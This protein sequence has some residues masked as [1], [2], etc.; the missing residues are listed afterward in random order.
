MINENG[1]SAVRDAVILVLELH[2]G[3]DKVETGQR[4]SEDLEVDSF[5]LMNIVVIL[6]QDFD[7]RISETAAASVRTVG[8][9]VSLVESLTQP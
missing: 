5:D 6:E 4:L 7:I 3:V 8:E 2:L 9:L 1:N